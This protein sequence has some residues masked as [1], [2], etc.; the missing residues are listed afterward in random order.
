MRENKKEKIT[1]GDYL[2]LGL[3]AFAGLGMEVLYAYLMEPVVYGTPMQ[4]WTNVQIILHW[5][6]TCITWGVFASILIQKSGKKYDFQLMEKGKTM[7]LWQSGLCAL[8]ILLAF[9]FDYI[10]WNGFKVYLEYVNKGFL[11]FTF[12]Y[13]YYAFETMLFLLIIIFGQKACEVW[14][15]KDKIPYGGIICG[16]TWGLAHIFTK[17]LLTGMSGIILGFAMGS[18]YLLVNRD[19]KKAYI[20]LFFMFVL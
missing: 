18:V 2:S 19:L 3:C 11:L 15:H 13:I 7:K 10:D 12:Q 14:F 6:L 8:F 20:A 16:L 1:G 17:D 4:D 9:I 5:I